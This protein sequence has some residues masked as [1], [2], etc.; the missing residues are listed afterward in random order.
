LVPYAV[1][2][3]VAKGVAVVVVVVMVVVVM[4]VL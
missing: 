1:L 2:F 4:M 3:F